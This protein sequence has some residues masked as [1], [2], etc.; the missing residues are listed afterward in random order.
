MKSIRC[1]TVKVRHISLR[2]GPGIGLPRAAAQ[3]IALHAGERGLA[4]GVADERPGQPD[5]VPGG[6]VAAAPAVLAESRR[7]HS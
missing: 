5:G 2:H 6:G 1:S 7:T 4:S 3:K